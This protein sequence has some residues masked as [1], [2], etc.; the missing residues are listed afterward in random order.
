MEKFFYSRSYKFRTKKGRKRSYSFD[1]VRRSKKM[2]VFKLYTSSNNEEFPATIFT[3][4]GMEVAAFIFDFNGMQVFLEANNYLPKGY[5]FSS[6]G[7]K[8]LKEDQKRDS[9]IRSGI[10]KP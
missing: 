8:Q 10:Y 9:N 6:E 7:H 3:Y 2:A 4:Q 1:L 5:S